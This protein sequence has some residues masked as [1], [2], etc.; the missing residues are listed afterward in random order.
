MNCEYEKMSNSYL[1]GELSERKRIELESHANDCI[2]CSKFINDYR[3]ITALVGNERIP[4]CAISTEKIMVKILGK[5]YFP[6]AF[7]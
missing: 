6:P 2:E 5:G 3:K 7:K 1:D 4:H